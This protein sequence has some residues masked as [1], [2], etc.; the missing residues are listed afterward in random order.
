MEYIVSKKAFPFFLYSFAKINTEA[1]TGC[2]Y[3][4]NSNNAET[5]NNEARERGTT[6]RAIYR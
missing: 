2:V 1:L 6:V 3:V 5:G 4:S